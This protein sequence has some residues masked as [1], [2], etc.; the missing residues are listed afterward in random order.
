MLLTGCL[1][2]VFRLLSEA[3]AL[4]VVTASEALHSGREGEGRRGDG[5]PQNLYGGDEKK[6]ERG[7]GK[8]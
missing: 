8:L 3:V 2:Q 7:E 1:L 4:H 6:E 5:G